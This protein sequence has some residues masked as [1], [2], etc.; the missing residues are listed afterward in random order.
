MAKKPRSD[1]KLAAL[2]PQQ[3][4][5]LRGWLVD[6]NLSY[7]EA[8]DRLWQDFRLR[9]SVGALSSFYASDC[10]SLRSSEAKDFAEHVVAELTASGDKF[11]EATLSLIRQKAFERAYA[12][13]G[14]LDELA[15]LAKII[16]D[17][18]KLAIKAREVA[19]AERR[20]KLLEK[21]AAQADA[22]ESSLRN[23]DLTP[24]EREAK[25]KEIFGLK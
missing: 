10:F 4:A 14:N 5:I 12:R 21:K 13:D 9:V 17:S 1:K 24:A 23:P 2:N 18:Q 8:R 7:A 11:D 20:L 15:T 22:A 19:L 6:D 16:G 3:R 25:L